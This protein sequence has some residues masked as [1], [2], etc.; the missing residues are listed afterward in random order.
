MSMGQTWQILFSKE[1]VSSSK[2]WFIVFPFILL[3]MTF[4]IISQLVVFNVIMT[5]NVGAETG[6]G[7]ILNYSAAAIVVEI[8]DFAVM[9]PWIRKE[10]SESK[11]GYLEYDIS[12]MNLIE[13]WV[14]R[15]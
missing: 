8:D 4:V 1:D 9:A 2:F 11:N 5:T 12:E 7:L 13:K 3:R 15:I 14:A 6:A 10:R